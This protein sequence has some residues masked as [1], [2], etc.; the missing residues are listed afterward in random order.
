LH[1]AA[2]WALSSLA[3][4]YLILLGFFG[5]ASPTFGEQILDGKFLCGVLAF[6]NSMTRFA[7]EC[8]GWEWCV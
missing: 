2:V 7:K 6:N 5:L 3:S 8:V 4:L 1:C